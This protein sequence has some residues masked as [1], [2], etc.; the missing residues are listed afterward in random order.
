MSTSLNYFS[1]SR[2][3]LHAALKLQLRLPDAVLVHDRPCHN[4]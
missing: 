4:P 2:N 3:S 1:G